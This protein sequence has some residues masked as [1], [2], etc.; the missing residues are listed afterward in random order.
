MA[1]SSPRTWVAL[2]V[3]TASLLNTHLRDNLLETGPA[4][5]TTQGDLLYATG[6]SALARLARGSSGQILRTNIAGTIPEWS[7][8]GLELVGS[9]TTEQ[10]TTATTAVDIVTVT[11]SKSIPAATPFLV[12]ASY[13]KSA[14]HASAAAV[15]IRKINA[16]TISLSLGTLSA[17]NQAEDGTSFMFFGARESNYLNGYVGINGGSQVSSSGAPAAA[18]S[19][20][21]SAGTVLPNA[22]V[23]SIVI[24]GNVTN[25]ANTLGVKSVQVYALGA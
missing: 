11:L 23:T 1:W 25:A 6:A 7:T 21:A 17:T 16:T 20:S 8:P 12:V 10:T 14:G 19:L 13:R 3:L 5:V 18:A 9:N 22:A 24:G 15:S 4:K 2:E